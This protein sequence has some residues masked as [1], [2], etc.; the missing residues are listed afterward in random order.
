MLSNVQLDDLALLAKTCQGDMSAYT[1]L[2]KR[3]YKDL[4]LFAFTITN[5]LSQSEEIA[6]DTF[7]KL[8]E[9]RTKICIET[10]LKSYLLKSVQ[11]K[12]I[13]YKKHITIKSSVLNSLQFN[14]RISD[15]NPDSYLLHSELL[16]KVDSI[17]NKLPNDVSAAFRKH[18]FEGLSYS[19]IAT[20]QGVS[21]RTIEVRISKCLNELRLNLKEYMLISALIINT[22]ILIKVIF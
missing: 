7:V 19:E 2:F 5:N 9:N 17:L 20:Q 4:T 22:L 1:L 10:S 18:R 11:N 16:E 12:C 15:L 8:W 3:Y 13:D 14:N 21:I 6:Q